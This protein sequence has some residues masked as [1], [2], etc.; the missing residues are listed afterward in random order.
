MASFDENGYA[1]P[2]EASSADIPPRFVTFV[3][4][5]SDGDNATV[6]LLTNDQPPF[7]DY[8][9]NC[10]RHDGRWHVDSGFPFNDDTPEEI[11]EQARSLGWSHSAE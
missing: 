8:Q 11:V 5:R 4:T 6:W 10:V 7:E 3:G 1:T 2:E 9:V